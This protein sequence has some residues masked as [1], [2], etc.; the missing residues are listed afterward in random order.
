[1]RYTILRPS[2]PVDIRLLDFDSADHL[3]ERFA[4]ASDHDLESDVVRAVREEYPDAVAMPVPIKIGAGE[5]QLMGVLP[6]IRAPRERE[7]RIPF[8]L[9]VQAISESDIDRRAIRKNAQWN[10]TLWKS[11]V[12]RPR[13]E[14][15][16]RVDV[17][18]QF[19]DMEQPM[20][21]KATVWRRRDSGTLVL[22][23]DTGNGAV[24]IEVCDELTDI[25]GSKWKVAPEAAFE[26]GHG[27]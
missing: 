16:E 26:G 19:A 11:T 3:R 25:F 7:G 22:M 18:V 1:M 10:R 6:S 20:P 14:D 24:S 5:S 13:V 4:V 9:I 23:I 21:L 12:L 15:F 17:N 8:V 2:E 27:V